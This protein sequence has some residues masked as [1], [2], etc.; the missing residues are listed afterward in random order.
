M[1]NKVNNTRLTDEQ[2]NHAMHMYG[3]VVT[4]QIRK[5]LE[6]IINYVY[7]CAL[8]NSDVKEEFKDI[9]PVDLDQLDK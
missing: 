2:L 4:F 5:H 7:E 3:G 8:S 1:K 6:N 9:D